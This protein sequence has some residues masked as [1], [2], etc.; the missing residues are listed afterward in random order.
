MICKM[1]GLK[2]D[3][4]KMFCAGCGAKLMNEITSDD[5]G[6]NTP[7]GNDGQNTSIIE[8]GMFTKITILSLQRCVGQMAP[9]KFSDIGDLVLY[10]DRFEYTPK[11]SRFGLRYIFKRKPIVYLYKDI[12]NCK[13]GVYSWITPYITFEMTNGNIVSFNPGLTFRKKPKQ[14]K[15]LWTKIS[16]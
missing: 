16:E 9:N 14:L 5:I 15:M 7:T 11:I 8:V 1:C 10:S 2:A 6:Q 4:N 13:D 3:D 12:K